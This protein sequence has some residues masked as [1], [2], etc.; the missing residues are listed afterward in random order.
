ME[1]LVPETVQAG[2]KGSFALW[3]GSDLFFGQAARIMGT[4]ESGPAD[5][6]LED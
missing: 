2:C 1:S 3:Y 5:A 4:L 6:R